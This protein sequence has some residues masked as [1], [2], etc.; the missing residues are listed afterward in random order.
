ME[1]RHI[2][3][4]EWH[5]I[6]EDPDFRALVNARRR[7]TVPA[8][9]FFVVFYFLLP[10]LAGFDRDLLSRPVWGP[11]TSGFVFAIAQF[12]VAWLLM[13][14]YLSRS[15]AF[16]DAAEALALKIRRRLE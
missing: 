12:A 8:S 4:D 7:F 9:I 5:R 6:S 15:R 2:S 11:L 14:L 1:H 16:D 10:V 3:D 13:G